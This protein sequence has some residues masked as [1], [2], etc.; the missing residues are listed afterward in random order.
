M[1]LR[2][3]ASPAVWLA[4][5]ATTG[6]L[7]IGACSVG[8]GRGEARGSLRLV[9]CGVDVP[10][11]DLAPTFFG[12]DF[13]NDPGVPG[14]VSPI[15]VLRVQRGSYRESDSDGLLITINDVN[16]LA[17]AHLG[18]PIDLAP[19]VGGRRLVD[20]TFYANETCEAGYPDEFWRVAGVLPAVSGTITFDAVYAPDVDREQTEFRGTFS[21]VR[22]ES[23]ERPETRNATLSG[24]FE[25]TYQR[26]TPAQRFP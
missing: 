1:R 22:F 2:S 16:E 9:E 19:V 17:R 11:Y 26:G 7:V 20:V 23:R 18:E 12:A 5:L 24:S 3:D 6:A 13:V 14:A 25:F 15:V 21:N 8:T 4:L 10:E